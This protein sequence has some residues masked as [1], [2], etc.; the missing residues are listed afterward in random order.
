[1]KN[2]NY[3]FN[4]RQVT[5]NNYEVIVEKQVSTPTE[6]RFEKVA[7]YLAQKH[8]ANGVSLMTEWGSLPKTTYQRLWLAMKIWIKGRHAENYIW[9]SDMTQD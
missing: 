8:G 2:I 4:I 7:S 3:R 1:M 5:L 9:E 6:I